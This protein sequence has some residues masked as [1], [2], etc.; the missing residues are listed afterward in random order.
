MCR[1]D[2]NIEN[3]FSNEEHRERRES[4]RAG[5]TF[6]RRRSFVKYAWFRGDTT[7]KFRA[8]QA[9]WTISSDEIP[10]FTGG[11]GVPFY[12]RASRVNRKRPPVDFSTDRESKTALVKLRWSNFKVWQL[13]TG[14]NL[15]DINTF[16]FWVI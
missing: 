3:Q 12:S 6:A 15:A 9:D 14:H 5:A 4:G 2:Y 16:Y 10:Q 13:I 8:R 1:N 11:G 7:P